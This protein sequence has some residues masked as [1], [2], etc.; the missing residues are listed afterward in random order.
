MDSIAD[1]EIGCTDFII[2]ANLLSSIMR[3]KWTDLQLQIFGTDAIT[4]PRLRWYL[5]GVNN[6]ASGEKNRKRP[7]RLA[8]Q[9]SA[10]S[11]RCFRL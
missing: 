1:Y 8:K 11:R 2:R 6:K 5:L 7:R 4:D 10:V 9:Q 3:P